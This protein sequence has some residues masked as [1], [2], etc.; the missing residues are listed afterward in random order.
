MEQRTSATT[1]R[2]VG[3]CC[4]VLASH[5]RVVCIASYLAHS[6]NSRRRSEAQLQGRACAGPQVESGAEEARALLSVVTAMHLFP[7]LGSCA[8]ARSDQ[9]CILRWHTLPREI[10]GRSGRERS[11]GVAR[12][13]GAIQ[14]DAA[15]V[16]RGGWV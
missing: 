7:R 2:A 15:A 12:R 1:E 11:V 14:T 9:T 10:G 16:A 5:E 8:C 4:A 6:L 13:L 3:Q